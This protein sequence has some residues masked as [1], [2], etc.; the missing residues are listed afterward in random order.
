LWSI[1]HRLSRTLHGGT[2]TTYTYGDAVELTSDGT[3]AHV[4]D[5]AGNLTAAGSD[6][7]SWD[8]ASELTSATVGSTTTTFTYAGDGTRSSQTTGATTATYL[9]DQLAGMPTLLDDGTTAYLQADGSN[10]E[11]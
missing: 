1:R 7:F 8:W 11:A 2:P 6:S 5:D 3:L 9:W 10:S 4:Y